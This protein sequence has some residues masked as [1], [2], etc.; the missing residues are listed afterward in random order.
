MWW[1]HQKNVSVMNVTSYLILLTLLLVVLC[2]IGILA[3]TFRSCIL[4]WCCRRRNAEAE[5]ENGRRNT[6]FNDQEEVDPAVRQRPFNTME[7]TELPPSYDEA[8]QQE[9]FRFRIP[10]SPVAG[11]GSLTENSA[12]NEAESLETEEVLTQPSTS[13]SVEHSQLHTA[14]SSTSAGQKI[15]QS[16]SISC[17]ASIGGNLHLSTIDEED[18][19]R[20]VQVVIDCIGIQAARLMERCE[21]TVNLTNGSELTTNS[22]C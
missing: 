13:T 2:I 5:G 7:Q 16:R 18:D 4:V 21:T 22:K 11:Q 20:P 15:R 10:S 9:L 14:Q 8:V 17:T 12:K 1:A 19:E 6:A 3:V